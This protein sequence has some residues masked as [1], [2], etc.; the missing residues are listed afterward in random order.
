MMQ[1]LTTPQSQQPGSV[2]NV[3]WPS[4]SPKKNQ[5]SLSRVAL[6]AEKM[7]RGWKKSSASI[8]SSMDVTGEYSFCIMI[9]V[10]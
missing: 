7:F 8:M 5:G 4:L 2:I 6:F 1:T 10:N 3:P 9:D